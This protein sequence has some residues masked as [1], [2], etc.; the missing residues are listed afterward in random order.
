MLLRIDLNSRSGAAVSPPDGP[1][2]APPLRAALLL[3]RVLLPLALRLAERLRLVTPHGPGGTVPLARAL[4]LRRR[5]ARGLSRR[6][7]R[8]AAARLAR[9]PGFSG[10]T[11]RALNRD[12]SR[13]VPDAA[14]HALFH[15]ACAG[16]PLFGPTRIARA[17]ATAVPPPAPADERDLPALR[18][19]VPRVAVLVSSHGNVF[20]QQIADDLAAALAAS[21]VA[22][23][24]LDETADRGRLPPHRII[25]APHEF[26]QLGRGR[27][28]IAD[29]VIARTVMLNTE[30]P[31][32]EWFTQA[33]PYVLAARGVIDL[34]AQSAAMFAATGLPA[35]H[36]TLVPPP[37]NASL[38]EADRA[39]PLFRV[40][41]AAARGDPDPATPFAARPL[42]IAF[43]GAATPHREA[44]LARYAKPFAAHACFLY[45]RKQSQG[46]IRGGGADG[47]LARIACHV[48]G[49]A[50]IALNLHRDPFGTFEWHRIV[51]LG[52]AMGSVVVSEPCLPH[53][54]IRA[55]EHYFEAP[56]RQLAELIGW[57][58]DSADGQAAAAR[59]Q[60]AARRLLTESLAP[61]RVAARVLAFLRD[62]GAAA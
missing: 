20:M 13:F 23:A 51:R 1:S 45:C 2:P 43:F 12:V 62:A 15:G 52:M 21:G 35:L 36:L 4:V 47:A 7:R 38:S 24:P 40:L 55:G 25:V 57:L 3:R 27:D 19:A 56:A 22:V 14:A 28:W 37:G 61:A 32:T 31:Q 39:H 41:P 53:P 17:L 58:L 16:R 8:L 26:F 34:G 9:L 11:Y 10:A 60:E 30:Q 48:G 46:P 33:L 50:R 6:R 42:D 44:L 29:D 49:H 18:A 5:L 59:M 54:N